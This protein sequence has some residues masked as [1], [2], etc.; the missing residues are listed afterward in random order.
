[1]DNGETE[2]DI[3]TDASDILLTGTVSSLGVADDRYVLAQEFKGQLLFF[4]TMQ[5][6]LPL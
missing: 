5:V 3:H 2:L 1:M 6:D 4:S